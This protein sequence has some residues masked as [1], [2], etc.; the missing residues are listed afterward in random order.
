MNT[1]SE[2]FMTI[3]LIFFI[4]KKWVWEEVG[5]SALKLFEYQICTERIISH[6]SWHIIIPTQGGIISLNLDSYYY[7]SCG[8]QA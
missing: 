3:L 1:A 7:I 4:W 2:F 5:W 8:Q 6:E